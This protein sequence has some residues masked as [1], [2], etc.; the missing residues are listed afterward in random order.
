MK[1]CSLKS[2]EKRSDWLISSMK[3]VLRRCCTRRPYPNQLPN[4]LKSPEVYYLLWAHRKFMG[5]K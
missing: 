1:K 5:E 3:W 4:I 2:R